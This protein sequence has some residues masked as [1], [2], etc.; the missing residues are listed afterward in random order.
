MITNAGEAH[1]EGFGG[2]ENIVRGKGEIIDG[3]AEGGTVVL[4]RDDP[5][6]ETWKQRAGIRRVVS[7]SARGVE[8][9]YQ[10]IGYEL[11]NG[12]YSIRVMTPEDRERSLTLNLPGEHNICNALLATAAAEAVGADWS[13]VLSGLQA[14]RPAAGRLGRKPLSGRITVIDDSYNANPPP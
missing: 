1:L 9:D 14:V 4:N 3:V 11:S 7:V 6:F 13:S 8:A 10:C 12:V 2:Y 5:A